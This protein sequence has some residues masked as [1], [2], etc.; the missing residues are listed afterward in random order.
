MTLGKRIK[1]LRIENDYT[2]EDLAKKLNVTMGAISSYERDQRFPIYDILL[3]LT[4]VFNVS[5]DYLLGK[6]NLRNPEEHTEK[7][8]I[9][10]FST[11]SCG[12][13]FIADEDIIDYEDI[14]PKLKTQGEHFGL[15]C[16]GDSMLPDF[17]DGDVAIVKKQPDIESGQIAVVLINGDEATMK[18]V[19]KSED[20]ITLIATNPAVYLPKFYTNEQIQTLPITIVG[21]VIESRRK[22]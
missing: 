6:S 14:D 12:N 7:Y 4:E 15:R 8:T 18:V 22:Y 20:G 11:I 17:K 19:E 5:Y 16:R 13:P 2:Q 21:R 3:K 1:Q 9:P 10:I